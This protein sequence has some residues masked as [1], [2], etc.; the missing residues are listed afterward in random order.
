MEKYHG[1]LCNL[2][3][4]NYMYSFLYSFHLMNFNDLNISLTNWF[5]WLS[6]EE[7]N[8]RL[9]P[10]IFLSESIMKI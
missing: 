4:Q 7:N 5:N 10:I 3:Y 8:K 6:H 9:L 1:S 2:D